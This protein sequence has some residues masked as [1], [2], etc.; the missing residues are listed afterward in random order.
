[1]EMSA[2]DDV[3][4]LSATE[5]RALLARME[6]SPTNRG[7]AG[8]S[9]SRA[10]GAIIFVK[11]NTPEFAVRS[12]GGSS[13]GGAAVLA[14]PGG[15]I[16]LT[17]GTDLGGSPRIPAALCGVVGLRP[18]PG[19]IPNHPSEYPWDTIQVTG[20]IVRT[21]EE[22]PLTQQDKSESDVFDLVYAYLKHWENISLFFG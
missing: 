7:C 16:S 3:V 2:P 10:A 21:D 12:A 15:M 9:T 14:A 17:E 6:V 4:Q 5:Q 13:G 22:V 11:T 8:H 1:M 18:L 20:F 19:L